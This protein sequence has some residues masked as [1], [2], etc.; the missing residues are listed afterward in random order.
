MKRFLHAWW[1]YGAE[2]SE[3]GAR[4]FIV[5]VGA[6]VA[7]VLLMGA[8]APS[9]AGL[10]FG[11]PTYW[12]AGPGPRAVAIGDLD[13]NGTLD[14]L[15][16]NDSTNVVT[17]L[18]GDGGYLLSAP[19]TFPTGTHPVAMA[20]VDFDGDNDLDVVTADSLSNTASVL[21]GTAGAAFEAPVAYFTSAGPCAIAISP[22]YWGVAPG[23]ETVAA[24]GVLTHYE[25]NGERDFFWRTSGA[26]GPNPCG[27]ASID[28]DYDGIGD[29]V[30]ANGDPGADPGRVTLLHAEYEYYERYYYYLTDS[31]AAEATPKAVAVAEI[32][33]NGWYD[34]VVASS[35]PG[36]G[37]ISVY[38]SDGQTPYLVPTVV[39]VGA[40]IST[41][42]VADMDLDDDLD[43]V[44]AGPTGRIVVLINDAGSLVLDTVILVGEPVAS[45]AV[46]D[47]D[48]ND[49]PDIVL[50]LHESR[51]VAVLRGG[52]VAAAP[53]IAPSAGLALHA[54]APH[55]ARNATTIAFRLDRAGET[56]VLVR[57]V[58]GRVVCV[59]HSGWTDAGEQRVAWDLRDDRHIPVASGRY[60]VTLEAHGRHATQPLV[61][62][63]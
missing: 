49:W 46:G 21:F 32:T 9:H 61:V 37:A 58:A 15:V 59:L 1:V 53:I 12:P 51:R 45:V 38:P 7:I 8:Q 3:R 18:T 33:A 13:G 44:A 29:A 11:T 25:A 20:V 63:R 55:P 39:Q 57:D 41:F 62:L 4:L 52:E 40:P 10:L 28:F 16:A 36:G 17:V 34:L 2:S 19:V 43:V 27:I 5:A 35:S 6:S 54:P 30:V 31:L 23:F 60:L 47:L 42:A 50:A 14:V 48:G 22:G 56:R 24:S 26:A